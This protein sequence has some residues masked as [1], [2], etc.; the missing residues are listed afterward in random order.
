MAEWRHCRLSNRT[1]AARSAGVL[2]IDRTF[3]RRN[4]HSVQ[5][6]PGKRKD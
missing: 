2:K 5:L 1:D 3:N 4:W 6:R